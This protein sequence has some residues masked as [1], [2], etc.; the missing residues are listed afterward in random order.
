MSGRR[1]P[2]LSI[3]AT[4]LECL[5]VGEME[6]PRGGLLDVRFLLVLLEPCAT[7]VVGVFSST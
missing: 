5:S 7:L 2:P 4:F 6:K 1:C 3:F